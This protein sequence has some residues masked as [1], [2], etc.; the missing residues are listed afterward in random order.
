M[1]WVGSKLS[2]QS[3]V[4]DNIDPGVLLPALYRSEQRYG[5]SIGM[6]AVTHR[7]LDGAV[8]ID[9]PI[10]EIGCGGG[11]LLH[12]LGER[13]DRHTVFGIDVHPAAL[14]RSGVATR[15]VAQADCGR[16]P[17]R[18]ELF[19]MV[20]ALDVFDQATVDPVAMLGEC[21][22]VLAACGLLVI[23]VSAYPW[24]RSPHDDAFGTTTRY[25]IGRLVHLLSDSG[26]EIVR[27][28]Y[29][30]ALLSL[31]AIFQRLLQRASV[32]PFSH[33]FYDNRLLNYLVL[34]ALRHEANWLRTRDIPFGLS[35][36]ALA[37]R[38]PSEGQK[39]EHR[40]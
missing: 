7:L 37:H 36:Y 4:T 5:W 12:E 20:L 35:L 18:R 39:S 16:L 13:F 31:P 24:L 19:A 17:F 30:N 33:G 3:R 10:L 38:E 26:F 25:S 32:L 40:K 14:A 23:R 21:R 6:R 15:T 11:T 22:R 27:L 2:K 28:T 1:N 9:G 8:P 29:A 34:R